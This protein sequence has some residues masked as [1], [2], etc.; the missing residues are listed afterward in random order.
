[1]QVAKVEQAV[2]C[3]AREHCA[4]GVQSVE[5]GI[6]K[7]GAEEGGV[8]EELPVLQLQQATR[9]PPFPSLYLSSSPSPPLAPVCHHCFCCLLECSFVAGAS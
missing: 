7:V 6:E 1:M 4:V 8:F 9:H 3:V 5:G 2:C